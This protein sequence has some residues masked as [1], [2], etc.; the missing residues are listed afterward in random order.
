MEKE[1]LQI[2]L[3]SLI[4][5]TKTLTGWQTEIAAQLKDPISNYSGTIE[6]AARLSSGMFK[7]DN[8]SPR[9][10]NVLANI[11]VEKKNVQPNLSRYFKPALLA[12]QKDVIFPSEQEGGEDQSAF[13][14]IINEIKNSLP[15]TYR[16]DESYVEEVLAILNRTTT[17]VPSGYFSDVSYYD[18]RRMTAA[19]AVCLHKKNQEEV[20]NYLEEFDKYK[21][22]PVALLVG[23]DISGI[24]DFIYTITAKGAAK[25]LRGRSFYLQL[26]TEAVLR[27]VLKKLGLP[28]TNV[29]YSGGGHFFL[30]APL[31]AAGELEK[32]QREIT[33]VILKHH[34]TSLY[35]ALGHAQIPVE[36]FF[37][38]KFPEYWGQMHGALAQRKQ[39]RYTE[40]GGDLYKRVF[41]PREFGGNP[42]DA[43]SACKEDHRETSEW[44]EQQDQSR[45]CTLCESFIEEIGKKLPKNGFI[46]LKFGSANSGSIGKAS[47]VLAEFGMDF[48]FLPDANSKVEDGTVIWTLDDPENGKLPG[49]DQC[50][51]WIRYTAHQV[52]QNKKGE[53]YGF[54]ELQEKV[55]GGFERLGVL[56][57]DVDNLGELFKIGLGNTA[58]LTRLASLS[59][60]ISLFFEGW[61]KA[62]CEEE[63][64]KGLIYT[65]YS[66]GDD[67]FLIGPWDLIPELAKHIAEDFAA[68]T[69]GNPAVH[70]SAGMTFIDGKYPVYQA[71]EDAKNAIDDAKDLDGKNAFTFLGEP[72]KWGVFNSINQKH[73]QL[74]N[75]VKPKEPDKKPAPQA[76][77][78][79]M[80]Q[81]ALEEQE[82]KNKKQ[83]G[84]HVWGRWIWMGMYQLTRMGELNKSTAEDIRAIRDGLASNNYQ[85]I[86]YWGVAARW[87]QLKERKKSKKED[88]K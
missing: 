76:L 47:D 40:L 46:A 73:N 65:V 26:L 28:Y 79:V 9:L 8:T 70:L 81:L 59:F 50:P 16:D 7:P 6:V 80:Q 10:E 86:N 34:G 61:L 20:E 5:E 67:V 24:Q 48:E 55:D 78:Q 44:A 56:R 42:D 52:P 75:L 18:Q 11:F 21:A 82:H 12:L 87:T 15:K 49:G 71:A 13:Q 27:F 35:L 85:E 39:R 38:G 62:L 33:Q 60:R 45:I 66:G 19:L 64:Y 72:W 25:S 1:T 41:V 84:R 58:T 68:Y 31:S 83:K 22:E 3:A 54:D 17:H 77:L 57:M 74:N 2:A 4:G 32:I 23:G 30:L 14:T 63:K 37:D 29:I 69:S 36:G 53:I 51:N 43:C 88:A